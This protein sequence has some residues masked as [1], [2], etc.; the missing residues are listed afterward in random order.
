MKPEPRQAATVDVGK[1]TRDRLREYVHERRM[2]LGETASLIIDQ[3]LGRVGARKA[4]RASIR[5]RK[6]G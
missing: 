4:L 1:E 6:G 5:P 3:Y 2:K